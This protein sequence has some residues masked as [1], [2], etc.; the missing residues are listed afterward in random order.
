MDI[1]ILIDKSGSMQTNSWH[2]L[3]GAVNNFCERAP[4]GSY[5]EIA[6][7]NGVEGFTIINKGHDL[8]RP[9][10]VMQMIPNGGTPLNDAIAEL[11]AV[12]K[13][14]LSDKKQ[15]VIL[16]DGEENA[17]KETSTAAA[18]ALLDECRHSGWDVVFLG[19]NYD[20]AAQASSLGS[21]VGATIAA[22][23]ANYGAASEI[24]AARSHAY[25][26]GVAPEA[27]VFSEDDRKR[28]G[29]RKVKSH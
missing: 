1:L 4:T 6:T 13:S 8:W 9:I 25:A 18:L 7:F 11:V 28:T 16:T 22:S 21:A 14:T 3:L 27:L 23:P 24:L 26:K 5:F 2:E 19:V 10:N 20:N 17:S 29:E 12:A 15:I